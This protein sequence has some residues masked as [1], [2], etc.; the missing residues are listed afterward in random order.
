MGLFKFYAV[1][2]TI[3]LL[4]TKDVQ[5]ARHRLLSSVEQA[6]P[7]GWKVHQGFLCMLKWRKQTKKFSTKSCL[8][9]LDLADHMEKAM[10]ADHRY[11]VDPSRDYRVK[12]CNLKGAGSDTRISFKEHVAMPKAC[13]WETSVVLGRAPIAVLQTT[14]DSTKCA[15]LWLASP[16]VQGVLAG[17]DF[18]LP[19]WNQPMEPGGKLEPYGAIVPVGEDTLPSWYRSGGPGRI[20]APYSL[21]PSRENGSAPVDD[22]VSIVEDV[23]DTDESPGAASA[24]GAE[25][26]FDESAEQ[27][28]NAPF[29]MRD[30][31]P[32]RIREIRKIWEARDREAAESIR[33]RDRQKAASAR[34]GV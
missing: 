11:C 26:K 5:S 4:I 3:L 10:L 16:S 21:R 29:W 13:F 22:D 32:D 8:V 15:R 24:V 2:C 9:R 12:V 6:L 14:M 30:I 33:E 31:S 19:S 17:S 25:T 7:P 20:P 23:D 27:H 1:G 34:T 18:M 28:V